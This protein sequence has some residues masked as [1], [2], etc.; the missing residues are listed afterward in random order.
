MTFAA[1]ALSSERQRS[2][3]DVYEAQDQRPDA[4]STSCRPRFPPVTAADG[5]VDGQAADTDAVRTLLDPWTGP[6]GGV[7]PFAAVEG[8]RLE[9]AIEAGMDLKWRE[10]EAITAQEAP[11]TFDNTILALERSG[12]S[13]SRSLVLY[14][15]W[16]SSLNTGDLPQIERRLAPK[17]AA[18]NDRILQDPR[19][20]ARVDAVHAGADALAPEDRQLT[21]FYWTRSVREGARLPPDSKRRL[22]AINQELAG[23]YTQFSQNL[24]ADEAEHVVYLTEADLSGL[25]PAQRRDA[26]AAA[27][28]LGRPDAFAILNTR[29]CVEP[30]LSYSDRRDLREVV[31]RAFASRGGNRDP[32]DNTVEII[33]RILKLRRRKAAF[34]GA[35]SYGAWKVADEMAGRPEAAMDLMMRIWP[36]TRARILDDLTAMQAIADREETPAAIAAWDWRYYAEKLRQASHAF[37]MIDVAPYL[38]LDRLRDALF[39]VAEELFGFTF[40]RA[41]GVEVFEPSVEVFDV[42]TREGRHLGLWYF[43]PYAREGKSSGAWM[44]AYRLQ[45]RFD[46]GASS[47]V[48]NTANFTRPPDGAPGLISWDD[49]RTLFHEFGHALHGLASDVAYPSLAGPNQAL[50]FVELPSQLFENWLSTPQVLERFAVDVDGRPMPADLLEKLLKAGRFNQG[51][52]VGEYLVAAIVDMRLH[53]SDEVNDL[54]PE[55]FEAAELAALGAPAPLSMRHRTPQF[56]HIFAGDGY[57]AGYYAYLW[58]EVLAL[59]A[60]QAFLQTGDPFDPA[61]AARFLREV[62]AVGYAV[63]PGTAYRR[64]RGRDAEAGAYFEAKG[65]N[66]QGLAAE[67][68]GTAVQ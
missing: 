35:P 64:F 62:L 50:D 63:D 11:P 49:A 46:G 42:R 4:G 26:A 18:F 22:T 28:R 5:E 37:E 20:F 7:P 3:G 21:R 19:L 15:I 29:S 10:I 31:W 27:A 59:D 65:F 24:L 51:F 16:T 38:Q 1:A 13:L 66:A 33:P 48:G 30:F 57:A 52:A 53:T 58:A 12:G 55:R 39:W 6:F 43:D 14:E 56:Q 67:R 9:R 36:P 8:R 40:A 47:L 25:P 17:L 45:H 61:T 60:Y 34:L 23:L 32:R 2:D 41:S 68:D 44:N 54:D